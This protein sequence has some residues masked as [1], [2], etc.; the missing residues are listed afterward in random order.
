[1]NRGGGAEKLA[2]ALRVSQEQ[3]RWTSYQFNEQHR[4]ARKR[5]KDDDTMRHILINAVCLP[6][7]RRRPMKS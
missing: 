6:C 2:G 3:L 5:R 4:T 1:M 7:R